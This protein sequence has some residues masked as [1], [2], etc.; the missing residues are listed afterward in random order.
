[1]LRCGLLQQLS[2]VAGAGRSDTVATPSTRSASGPS[3]VSATAHTA[4]IA[5]G[6]SRRRCFDS[7][8]VQKHLAL[9]KL[10]DDDVVAS[11]DRIAEN[12]NLRLS[13]PANADLPRLKSIVPG[14]K[15]VTIR[16]GRI[17]R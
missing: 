7:G 1:M 11:L 3:A 6:L 10:Q 13:R 12:L 14:H 2:A 8:F 5:A 16:T 15:N 9:A 4:E 17:N